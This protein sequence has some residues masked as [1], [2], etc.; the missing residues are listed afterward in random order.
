M[1]IYSDRKHWA[2]GK[3]LLRNI[4]FI[5]FYGVDGIFLGSKTVSAIPIENYISIEDFCVD[6]F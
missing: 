1:K 3:K 4:V 6:T 5:I 2:G